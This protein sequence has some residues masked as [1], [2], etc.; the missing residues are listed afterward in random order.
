[1][2]Y[3]LMLHIGGVAGIMD[4]DKVKHFVSEIKGIPQKMMK[5]SDQSAPIMEMARNHMRYKSF[6]FLGRGIN[7]PTVLEGAFKFKEIFYIHAEAYAAG[8]MKHGPIALIDDSLPV[9]VVSPRDQTYKKTCSNM[10]EVVTR[11][12][13]TLLF[14]DS[15]LHEMASRA[16]ASFIFSE[17]IYELEPLLAIV[18][19]Q[20]FAYH[21]AN[22]IGTDLDQPRNLAK[23]V[24]VE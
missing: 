10:E 8:E 21:M 12:G 17:T 24:T 1:V 5:I 16:E 18:P 4:R 6:L 19:L 13:K 3:L 15:G 7:Y 22:L 14:T 23:S 11:R 2:L 9:V 20:L